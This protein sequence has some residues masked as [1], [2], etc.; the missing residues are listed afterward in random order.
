MGEKKKKLSRIVVK[1]QLNKLIELFQKR[2]PKTLRDKIKAENKLKAENNLAGNK[3]KKESID[4]LQETIDYLRVCVKYTLYDLEATRR[5]N[6]Q[7][8][9]ELGEK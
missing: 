3:P 4:S 7:L 8:R 5:E 9:K 1:E 2:N 6:K